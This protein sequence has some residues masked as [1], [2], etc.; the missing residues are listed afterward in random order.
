MWFS[1]TFAQDTMVWFVTSL[2]LS[3]LYAYVSI[4]IYTYTRTH[5]VSLSLSSKKNIYIRRDFTSCV[6]PLP[7]LA[8]R[9]TKFVY[10]LTHVQ[11]YEK[12]SRKI[13]TNEQQNC[14]EKYLKEIFSTKKGYYRTIFRESFVLSSRY[15]RGSMSP[16]ISHALFWPSLA[17]FYMIYDLFP[18]F[19]S[20]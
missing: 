9:S 20:L 15:D 11:W 3:K 2:H 4:Y 17:L 6:I 19:W 7:N 13:E 12:F 1:W 10:W 8:I 5:I 14:I 18:I 16:T